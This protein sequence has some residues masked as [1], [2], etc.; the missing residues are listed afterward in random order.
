MWGQLS[1]TCS[2]V[3][4]QLN[5]VLLV[6]VNHN[7]LRTIASET[8]I[9]L[10][11]R[12]PHPDGQYPLSVSEHSINQCNLSGNRTCNRSMRG[13]H[14]ANAAFQGINYINMKINYINMKI[15]YINMKY[16]LYYID[17]KYKLYYINMNINYIN[18]NINY[19]NKKNFLLI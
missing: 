19:I 6:A 4:K 13:N 8:V 2:N 18:I 14:L 11:G 15:N 7:Q 3:L 9:Q 16:K 5:V 17:M 10:T 1:T 12:T